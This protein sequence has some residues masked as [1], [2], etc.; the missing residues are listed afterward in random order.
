MCHVLVIEDEPLIAEYVGA[1]AEMAGA[2]SYTIADTV[3]MAVHAARA[4]T[5][6]LILSD[7]N[8]LRGDRGPDAVAQIRSSMG[9]IPVIFITA[10]AAD[11]VDC[12]YASA[13]L[14]KPVQPERVLAAIAAVDR[15]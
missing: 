8:L 15:C 12:D 9:A 14:E 3:D 13:I 11:C 2:K 7:V 1:L 10:T 6:D 4:Q 5:P